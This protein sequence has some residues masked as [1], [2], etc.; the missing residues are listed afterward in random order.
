MA[1]FVRRTIRRMNLCHQFPRPAIVCSLTMFDEFLEIFS[2]LDDREKLEV[3]VGFSEELA[4]VS[5]ARGTAPFPSSCR[6]QE[7]QTAVHL[8]VD[9]VDGK[10]QLE[11][12]VPRNSVTVRGLVAIIVNA[13]NGAD[14]AAVLDLPEDLLPLL[15]LESALGMTRRQGLRGVMSRIHREIRQQ[16]A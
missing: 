13:L 12:D 16:T 3:I 14:A 5:A 8:W 6:V 2:D 15:G 9:V 11:A 1:Q 7:C 10:V 4:P